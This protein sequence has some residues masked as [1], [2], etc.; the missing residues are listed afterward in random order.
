M[1]IFW[2]SPVVSQ[3]AEFRGG[4]LDSLLLP[5]HCCLWIVTWL[6]SIL[7]CACSQPGCVR[8]FHCSFS[9]HPP[10]GMH[11]YSYIPVPPAL[12]SVLLY[13]LLLLCAFI[14]GGTSSPSHQA[15]PA[16]TLNQSTVFQFLTDFSFL[17]LVLAFSLVYFLF[18]Y[19]QWCSGLTPGS[20]CRDHSWQGLGT[21][22]GL[23]DRT[24]VIC[25]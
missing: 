13:P 5:S 24:P 2:S 12:P 20:E 7:S 17:T 25:M 22:C 4:D 6:L 9:N 8:G 23:E 16:S 10:A 3:Q 1:K 15:S 21:I 14:W 19:I 11:F 18:G